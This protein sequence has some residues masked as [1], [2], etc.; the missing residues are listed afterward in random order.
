MRPTES[1]HPLVYTEN[2]QKILIIDDEQRIVR[3]VQKYFEQAG[4]QVQAA[5]D[6]Q[7]GLS[8]ARTYKPDLIVLDLML[9]GMDGLDV[10]RALRRDS[11]V[12]VIM[13]TARVEETDK[14][15]GLELGA[16]DYV[17]KPFSPRELVAR[18]RAVLR[19]SQAL[20]AAAAEVYQFGQ[21]TFEVGTHQCMVNGRVEKL[22]PTEFSFLLHL[23]RHRR[24]VC[25]RLQLLE[26]ADLGFY[27]GVE[28][29][30]DV[31][32]HNL[33]HKIEPDP[34]NPTHIQTVFGV[35]YRFLEEGE[36]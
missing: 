12:P 32:I 3:G 30:V 18:A 20:S 28:R 10:C 33:R 5:Y 34:A 21:V 14:L 31:H 15:I 29:T 17:T 36:V 19:R 9:P 35:G 24:Q 7:S 1:I 8:M 6:G 22:T 23:V 16:D 11:D 4:F 27:E 13:L 25:S 2:M 26:A